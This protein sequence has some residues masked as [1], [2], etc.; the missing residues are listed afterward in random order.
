MG[1]PQNSKGHYF[2]EK[3]HLF[4]DVITDKNK[5]FVL[6]TVCS[7]WKIQNR[8]GSEINGNTI[9]SEIKTEVWLQN[10]N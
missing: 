10:R 4:G 6:N 5:I 1:S 7:G 9:N 2:Q 3:Q 8:N